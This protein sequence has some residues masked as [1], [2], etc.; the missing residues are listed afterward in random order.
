MNISVFRRAG[1]CWDMFFEGKYTEGNNNLNFTLQ[2]NV[3]TLM[4]T[5]TAGQNKGRNMRY[6]VMLT[7][8]TP[9]YG[10]SRLW[11]LCPR[12]SRRSGRLYLAPGQ[13]MYL[14]RICAD[15]TYQSTRELNLQQELKRMLAREARLTAQFARMG[16]AWPAKNAADLETDI[17]KRRG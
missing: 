12:C 7:R 4:Y 6:R 2:N 16:I 14:C 15:L 8:T 5:F 13:L 11:F 3:L 10:G 1:I 17:W 9:N